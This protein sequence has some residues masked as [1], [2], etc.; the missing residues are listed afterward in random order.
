MPRN[1]PAVN[2]PHPPPAPP[3]KRP[4]HHGRL[5]EALVAAGIEALDR[6]PHALDTRGEG[7]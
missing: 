7:W 3:E 4:Y 1:V 2:I 5:R 6:E